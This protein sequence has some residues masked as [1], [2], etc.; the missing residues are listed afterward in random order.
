MKLEITEEK[1]NIFLKRK[2]YM[3]FISHENEATPSK[4]RL[5]DELS[6]FLNVEK[7]KID[8]KY[9][10]SKKGISQSIAKVWVKE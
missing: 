2:E 10:M 4:Q 8:I 6:K 3:I 9:I 1:Q 5:L 7:E